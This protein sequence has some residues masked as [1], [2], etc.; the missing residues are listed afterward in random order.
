MYASVTSGEVQPGKMDEY[1]SIYRES[2][3][4]VIR[5]VPEVKQ[6]FVLTDAETNKAM[7][8]AIYETKDDAER[9]RNSGDYQKIIEMIIGAIVPESISRK[10][11]EVSIHM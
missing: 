7:T 2:V 11:Y 10:G 8:V 6:L 9:T 4:P 3:M 5:E 1:L